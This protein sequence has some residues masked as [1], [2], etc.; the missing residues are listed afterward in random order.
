MASGVCRLPGEEILPCFIHSGVARSSTE[1][2]ARGDVKRGVVPRDEIPDPGVV[3]ESAEVLCR[4]YATGVAIKEQDDDGEILD[5]SPY[6][7]GHGGGMVEG[8]GVGV[9]T[10]FVA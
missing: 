1:M 10:V 2:V 5:S 6:A 7:G 9:E 8:V 3:V 4:R